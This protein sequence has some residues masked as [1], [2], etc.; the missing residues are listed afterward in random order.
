MKQGK[1]WNNNILAGVISQTSNNNYTFEYDEVYFKNNDLP[2]ISLT[3]PKT[4]KIYTSSVLFPF[5]F[6]LLSEG[7]N[8]LLQS[9]LLKIDEDDS[10][11]FLLKTANLET[12]GAIKVEEIIHE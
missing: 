1:V 3:L 11:E 9:K 4:Q 7:K 10:F 8:K 12:I 2:A 6:S 5:F